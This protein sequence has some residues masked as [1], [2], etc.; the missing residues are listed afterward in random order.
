VITDA[1]LRAKL[2]AAS[3]GQVQIANASHLVVFA[4]K[5]DYSEADV[6][7][8][9]KHLAEV[10]GAPIEA[11]APLRGMLVG[12]I[13]KAQDEA[14]RNAWARNRTSSDPIVGVSIHFPTPIGPASKIL[15]AISD[16]NSHRAT[17]PDG[18]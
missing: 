5:D 17:P 16:Q 15:G 9:L 6:D 13:V 2:Q 12:S 3:Y 7:A 4:S 10:R 14:A 1:A 11:L 18:R 8:H